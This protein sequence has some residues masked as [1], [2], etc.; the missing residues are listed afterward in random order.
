MVML[1]LWYAIVRLR[2]VETT[3]ISV[4]LWTKLLVQCIF[5]LIAIE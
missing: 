4:L 1:V 3:S 5:I 2:D